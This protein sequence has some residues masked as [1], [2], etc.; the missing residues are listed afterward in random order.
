MRYATKYT[1]EQLVD[2]LREV[3]A[4]GVKRQDAPD[5]VQPPNL[6]A[7]INNIPRPERERLLDIVYPPDAK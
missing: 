7:F 5:R 6:C 3:A 1:D 4:N 2:A